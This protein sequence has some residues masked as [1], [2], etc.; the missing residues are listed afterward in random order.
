MSAPS[1]SLLNDL[2]KDQ[3]LQL[4]AYYKMNLNQDIRLKDQIK[5]LVKTELIER[6]I[7][8]SESLEDTLTSVQSHLTFEQQKEL[9]VVQTEMKEKLLEVQNRIEFSKIQLQQQQL[10]LERYRFDL[11]RDGKLSL[12]EESERDSSSC[13]FD[14]VRN[15]RLIPKFDEKEVERF[16]LLFERVADAR[17]GQMKSERLCYNLYLQAEPK[18]HILPLV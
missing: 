15:L 14:T 3:L 5:A 18:K 2:T 6:G 9:L 16:F 4:V 17:H 13:K 1:V 7:L 10:E 12:T 11:V 8:K